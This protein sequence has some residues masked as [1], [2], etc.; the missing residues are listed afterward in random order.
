M[1]GTCSFLLLNSFGISLFP[2]KFRVIGVSGNSEFW[3]VL[4]T[5]LVKHVDS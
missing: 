3:I 5:F 2:L 4:L 1:S